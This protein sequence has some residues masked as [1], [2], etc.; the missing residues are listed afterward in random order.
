MS[1]ELWIKRI[2]IIAFLFFVVKLLLNIYEKDED[3]GKDT[4]FVSIIILFIISLIVYII[5]GIIFN[6]LGIS[7]F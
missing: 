6:L 7:P 2:L 4:S 3:N 5:G 1:E